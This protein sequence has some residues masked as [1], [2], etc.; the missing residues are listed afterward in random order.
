MTG[1]TSYFTPIEWRGFWITTLITFGVY[2]YTLAPNVTLEDSGEFLTAAYHWGV[3]HPPG[4]PVWAISANLFVRAIPFGNVAW[5]VNLMSTFYGALAA[6]ML[7]LLACKLAGRLWNLERFKDFSL[8]GISRNILILMVGIVSGLVFAFIDTMWSQAVI[9]EVYT[10]NSFFFTLLCLLVLRWFDAPHQ[11]RWPCFLA[12]FFGLGITNHQTILVNAPVFLFAMFCA[13]RILCRDTSLLA[14][15]ACSIF[16][17]QSGLWF[18]WPIACLLLYFYGYLAFPNPALDTLKNLVLLMISLAL[19]IAIINEWW[20]LVIVLLLLYTSIIFSNPA[21]WNLRNILTLVFS[22]MAG[23]LAVT[24]FC[25][26]GEIPGSEVKN[27]LFSNGILFTDLIRGWLFVSGV[28]AI[29]WI[30][31]LIVDLLDQR[32]AFRATAV[33]FLSFTPVIVSG[34]LAWQTGLKVLWVITAGFSVFYGGLLFQKRKSAGL[35][36]IFTLIY[37]LIFGA[38]AVVACS[39]LLVRRSDWD[40]WFFNV[41]ACLGVTS[42]LFAIW[43]ILLLYGKLSS[44][45]TLRSAAPFILSFLMFVG[46]SS[47]YLYM[48]LSSSTNPPMNWGHTKEIEGFRHHITR[49]QYER[50]QVRRPGNNIYERFRYLLAQ[51]GLFFKDLQENFSTPLALLGI[52]PLIFLSEFPKKEKEYLGFT[53]LCFIFM[54]FVLVYLLNPKFDAQSVFISRVF[55]ALVHGIYSLWIGLGSI[56]LLYLAQKAHRRKLFLGFVAVMVVL[57]IGWVLWGKSWGLQ[58]I[59]LPV[60]IFFFLCLVGLLRQSK[61][62]VFAVGLIFALPIIPFTMNWADSE[63]RGHDFGWKYGHDMLKDLDRDAVVYGGTDPGR[64]VP[65]Y[66]I[67]VESFQP[68]RWKKDPTFDRRDLYIITQNALADQTYMNYIRDHYDVSR[69]QMN[70][71]Y[72]KFLGRDRLYPREPLRLPTQEEFNQ[73][74]TQVVQSTKNNPNNGVTFQK[75]AT[76]SALRASV[77]GVEG[78]FVINGAIARW[79]F[80]QNKARHTFYVEESY[81]ILW[82]Y[83]YLEPVGLIMKL[84]KEPLKTLDLKVIEKDMAYWDHLLQEF[85]PSAD[86]LANTKFRKFV[87]KL[88]RF[89]F[90]KE[91]GEE[92]FLK[93]YNPFIRDDVAQKSFSKLR[94]S[95]GGVYTF[96]SMYAVAEKVF[97]QALK[98]YPSSAEARARLIEIYT[99]QGRFEDA[100][101]ICEEW[102]KLDPFNPATVEVFNRVNQAKGLV[103]KEKEMASLYEFNQRDPNFIF[104]YAN[105]LRERNKWSEA[106]KIVDTFFAQNKVDANVWQMAIQFYA[107]FNRPERIESILK[108]WSKADPK[109]ASVWLNIAVVQSAM[110]KGDQACDSLQK[111]LKLDPNLLQTVQT[112]ARFNQIRAMERFQKMLK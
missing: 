109:N 71:W 39:K 72:H 44:S 89:L 42:V 86:R 47:V 20:V 98:F 112:D 105:V 13:D 38:I 49:G 90:G 111:A 37:S 99:N 40:L 74:F 104:Q 92:Y 61:G 33:L 19:A 94:S 69:P 41:V 22:L 6:G 26:L 9:T 30:I 35:L 12:L 14:A 85:F 51:Y 4:Y 59:W 11:W 65:T 67:F 32:R 76:G 53:V 88:C 34:V 64:F 54:G 50:I 79:I 73:I 75:G 3:P 106:D 45:S 5:R 108:G 43:A 46:G 17:W 21:F 8:P 78:V 103:E 10:L 52:L 18:M 93:L 66:M 80:E 102:L 31:L 95:I 62:Q 28:L 16:A 60:S 100:L 2:F 7:S 48:P 97:K 82:M 83:P 27:W 84:N 110:S 107:Q 24:G 81:P 77:Q 96:R 91:E 29:F 70:Q 57:V 36:N 68:D 55:Y 58:I 1:K 63:M 23:A 25:K 56:F 87:F 15:I 101:K